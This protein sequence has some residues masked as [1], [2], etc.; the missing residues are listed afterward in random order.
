MVKQADG[1]FHM[2][3]KLHG[4]STGADVVKLMAYRGGCSMTSSRTGRKHTYSR[5]TEVAYSTVLLPSNAPGSWQ[6]RRILAEA[7]E[8]AECRKD[9]QLVR[10]IEVALPHELSFD[11]QVSLLHHFIRRTFVNAGMI[12]SLDIHNK[13]G[14]P[15]CHI[16]LSLRSVT[17]DGFG[18]KVRGWN[19]HHLA[20]SWRERWA[21]GCN[22]ALRLAGSP[23]RLD[24]RSYK[25]RGLD[26]TPTK[27]LGTRRDLNTEKWDARA[28]SNELIL[29]R[30]Q[31]RDA[32]LALRRIEQD[33][34]ET[35][36]D[37]IDA[38]V[39]ETRDAMA[40]KPHQHGPT[41]ARQRQQA[42][43]KSKAVK[44]KASVDSTG[45]GS[46]S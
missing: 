25:R 8:S 32:R 40:G 44:T 37:V 46:P 28:E 31:I 1:L 4:R 10:E 43:P 27:H 34:S 35:H 13:P 26:I 18:P 11:Q 33:F 7:I 19:E 39:Q 17:P 2:D 14:N 45:Y 24:H 42:K 22:A 5:K 30:R 3:V 12:A 16:L 36:N 21:S 38:V 23:T 15:H 20:E 41:V 29:G 6:D 9:A